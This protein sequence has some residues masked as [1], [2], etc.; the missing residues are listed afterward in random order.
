MTDSAPNAIAPGIYRG[1]NENPGNPGS[2][3]TYTKACYA[4]V[5]VSDSLSGGYNRVNLPKSMKLHL[6]V[7]YFEPSDAQ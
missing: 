2:P 3:E 4:I 5:F 1:L 6:K 7:N